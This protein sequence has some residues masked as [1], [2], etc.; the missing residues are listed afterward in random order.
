MSRT[1]TVRTTLNAFAVADVTGLLLPAPGAAEA[2]GNPCAPA[3]SLVRRLA[4]I[5]P[6]LDE[7]LNLA[8]QP[9]QSIPSVPG[10]AS[11]APSHR[12]EGRVND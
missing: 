3:P 2:S 4:P 11:T 10:P 6:D 12:K 8:T 9:Q 1:A 5:A 7:G